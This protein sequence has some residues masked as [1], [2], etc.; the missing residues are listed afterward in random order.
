MKIDN[1]LINGINL[2][3]GQAPEQKKETQ[4]QSDKQT[5]RKGVD[6]VEFS[7]PRE[8]LAQLKKALEEVPEVR[9][10]K[11][12]GV[13]VQVEDGTYSVSGRAVAAKMLGVDNE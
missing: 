8:Q 6:R 13:K 11:V 9:A 7:V 2:Y 5:Q 4:S 3:K 10:D 1:S 12:A